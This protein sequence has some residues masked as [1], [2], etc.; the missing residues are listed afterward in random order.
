MNK[1]AHGGKREGAGRK[2]APKPQTLIRIAATPDEINIIQ[3][4]TPRERA[5]AMV[6]A[7]QEKAETK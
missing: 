1:P 2:P 5:E 7:A 3:N 6:K 4:L